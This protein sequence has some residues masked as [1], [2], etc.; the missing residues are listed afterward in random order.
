MDA[1]PDTSAGGAPRD[2]ARGI[3][4]WA[5]LRKAFSHPGEPIAHDP[6]SLR[7]HRWK[8]VRRSLAWAALSMVVGATILLPV[9]FSL[10]TARPLWWNA[11][12][13]ADPGTA[14]LAADLESTLVEQASMVRPT[15]AGFIPGVPGEWRSDAWTVTVTS[16]QAAA[17][18]NTRFPAWLVNRSESVK[19]PRELRAVAADFSDTSI[20]L[21]GEFVLNGETRYLSADL[22]LGVREDGSL[23]TSADWL[24]VGRLPLPAGWI[25]KRAANENRSMI[26]E[27]ASDV[28]QMSA[29]LKA[30][31]GEAAVAITPSLSL[32]DG[33]RVRLLSIAPGEGAIVVTCRT[34][35]NAGK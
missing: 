30:L 6:L 12:D 31:A 29:A 25:L 7:A 9:L 15:A 13:V 14:A 23:W 34:E 20:T 16:Q 28:P 5:R 11:P 18:L 24:R 1:T 35:L 4:L 3:S 8:L 22:S 10:G 17:W 21:G 33:R 2:T 27:A 19:W 32:G 26:P